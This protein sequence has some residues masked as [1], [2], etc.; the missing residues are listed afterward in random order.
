MQ[1]K[2]SL[3]PF[4]APMIIVIIAEIKERPNVPPI[5]QIQSTAASAQNI[6]L[7]LFDMG[8]GAFWRTGNF[9]SHNNVFIA[10]E[11]SLSEKSEVLGYLYVGTPSS[12]G[13]D[14]TKLN[15]SD[16]VTYWN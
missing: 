9:T 1:K 10:E 16:Y 11:L 6:L 12:K 5:E 15:N 2:F 3:M 4:R 14:I 13:K 8:F 7:A